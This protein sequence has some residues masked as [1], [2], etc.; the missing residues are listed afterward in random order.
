MSLFTQYTS[1]VLPERAGARAAILGSLLV[2]G[3]T[4]VL[5]IPLGSPRPCTWRSSPTPAGGTTG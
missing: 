4:A 1:Q 2:I 3:F 5:A